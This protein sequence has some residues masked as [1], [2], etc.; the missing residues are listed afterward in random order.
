MVDPFAINT[1]FD[2]SDIKLL[3]AELM[4]IIE[5]NGMSVVDSEDPAEFEAILPDE[6]GA[7]DGDLV[8]VKMKWN[9]DKPGK[10]IDVFILYERFVFVRAAR[11]EMRRVEPNLAGY[12]RFLSLRVAISKLQVPT[13]LVS[14][15]P[16]PTQVST[17]PTPNP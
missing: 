8:E 15:S 7:P 13:A 4:K 10:R 12:N 1:S 5:A 16:M 17:N 2:C 3:D 9:E 6:P 14:T 11:N